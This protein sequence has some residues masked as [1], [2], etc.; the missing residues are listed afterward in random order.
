[1]KV[2]F[3]ALLV[4]C[5]AVECQVESNFKSR[6]PPPVTEPDEAPSALP[7]PPPAPFPTVQSAAST[8]WDGGNDAGGSGDGGS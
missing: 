4:S 6:K 5:L 3:A 7:A 8:P 2:V 1:M